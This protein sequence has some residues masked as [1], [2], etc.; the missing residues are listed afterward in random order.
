[1]YFPKFIVLTILKIGWKLHQMTLISTQEDLIELTLLYLIHFSKSQVL[2]S[3]LMQSKNFLTKLTNWA[4]P[5]CTWACLE[6]PSVSP[7]QL[8][9]LFLIWFTISQ[10]LLSSL[11]QKRI[12]WLSW[13]TG[14]AQGA[15]WFWLPNWANL[16]ISYLISKIPSSIVMQSKNFLLVPSKSKCLMELLFNF[17]FSIHHCYTRS[18]HRAVFMVNKLFFKTFF[19]KNTFPKIFNVQVSL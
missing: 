4:C 16:L 19:S 2:L 18:P 9:W 8:T 3:C 15:Q 12:F 5:E 1:M 17:R 14:H 7:I 11:M 13:P 6:V 10:V